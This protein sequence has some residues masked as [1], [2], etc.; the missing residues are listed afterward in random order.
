MDPLLTAA[1]GGIRS[2]I[3]SLDI[4]ANNLA[5]T[6]TTGYKGD[7][8]HYRSY[9]SDSS[10]A[11]PSFDLNSPNIVPDVARQWIDFAQGVIQKT[12]R[13]LDVAI[14]GKGFFA[15]DGPQGKLFTRNGNLQLKPD[16]R[17]TTPEGY[18]V[19]CKD[20]KPLI[21]DPGQAVEI[22]VNGEIC[23][24]GQTLGQIALFD[25]V[26]NDDIS[27][28]GNS[29][30]RWNSPPNPVSGTDVRQGFLENSNISPAQSAVRLISI[31]RQ[32]ETVQR[33]V[34]LSTEMN[35]KAVEE[36]SRVSS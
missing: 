26:N 10:F 29:Y 21:I 35:R 36:V 16:G 30:F 34:T 32:F 6:N 7:Q 31:M 15:V 11:D 13:G 3:E 8:E 23:Q 5:N 12:D 9:V 33:A 27:K 2:R 20:G 4:L 19:L 18:S 1:A 25:S 17:I 28:V 22:G 14:T 24:Q